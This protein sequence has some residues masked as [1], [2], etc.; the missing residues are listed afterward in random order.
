[1]SGSAYEAVGE[2]LRSG[3]RRTL[4][5]ALLV[6]LAAPLVVGR[7]SAATLPPGFQESVVFSGLTAPTAVRFSPDGR[8]F[9]AE[10]GGLVKVFDSLSDPTPS[11]YADLRTKVHAF[12]DRGLLGLALHPSFPT[13][14]DIYV[15]YAHDATIGGTAPRWGSPG[16]DSDPCQ[17]GR[18]HV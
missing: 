6:A 13:V 2:R 9:V 1:M 4:W 14:Q 18:A 12:N 5:L 17:I 10:Q 3:G 15:S 16:A 7:A 11:I 8:V